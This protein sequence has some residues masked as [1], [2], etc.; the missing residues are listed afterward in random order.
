MVQPLRGF[1]NWMFGAGSISF[2]FKILTNNQNAPL[3]L[4]PQ[5]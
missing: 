4:I 3:V 1:L 2:R 5:T